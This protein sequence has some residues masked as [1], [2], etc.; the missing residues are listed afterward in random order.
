[1]MAL[2]ASS[3]VSAVIGLLCALRVVILVVYGIKQNH[4]ELERLASSRI[5]S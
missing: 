4:G 3:G 2:L 1:M 5:A